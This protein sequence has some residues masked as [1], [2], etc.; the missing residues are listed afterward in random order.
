MKRITSVKY[1]AQQ[2]Q[3]LI[4]FDTEPAR[5]R[6]RQVLAEAIE[7]HKDEIRESYNAGTAKYL[8]GNEASSENYYNEKF[9]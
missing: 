6:Y 2:L 7:K 4:S 8:R 1:L 5:E 3:A 9:Q